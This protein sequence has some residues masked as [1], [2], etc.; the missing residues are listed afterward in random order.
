MLHIIQHKHKHH[1][2]KRLPE[3]LDC[4]EYKN[5][6]VSKHWSYLENYYIKNMVNLWKTRDVN[7]VT[8]K[9]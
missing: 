4:Y 6:T 2:K 1:K 5:L 9:R 7:L 3:A 8:S